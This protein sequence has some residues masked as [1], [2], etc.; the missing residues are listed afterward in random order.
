MMT[1]PLR[2]LLACSL[3]G[4][5]SCLSV[6]CASG[7]TPA[8]AQPRFS[9]EE[10][11]TGGAAATVA[12]EVL[13]A[14]NHTPEQQTQMSLRLVLRP[15]ADRPVTVDLGPGWYFTEHGIEFHPH[16][17]VVVHGVPSEVNGEPVIIAHEL[18]RGDE[19]YQRSPGDTNGDWHPVR[20][21]AEPARP[22]PTDPAQAPVEAGDT[23]AEPASRKPAEN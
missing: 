9:V 6:A 4:L 2:S 12:G 18:R 16:D 8:P 22:E 23:N 21:E 17:R 10:P 14:D 15:T 20:S 11:R 5:I 3:S 1:H 7:G 19:V 13:G